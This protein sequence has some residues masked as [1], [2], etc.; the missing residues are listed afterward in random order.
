M[1]KFKITKPIN[2][3]KIE[4]KKS[5]I[6]SLTITTMKFRVTVTR[7]LIFIRS[8]KFLDKTSFFFDEIF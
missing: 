8:P 6:K 5:K 2:L 7:T 4:N 3:R 1:L